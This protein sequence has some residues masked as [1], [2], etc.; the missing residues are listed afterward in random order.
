MLLNVGWSEMILLIAGLFIGL[1]IAALRARHWREQINVHEEKNQSLEMSNKKK[2]TQLKDLKTSVQKHKANIE[3]LSDK[4]SQSIENKHSLTHQVNE[5]DQAL[6]QLKEEAKNLVGQI[7]NMNTRATKAET[8]N[9]ELEKSLKLM[10]KGFKNLQTH[11]QEQESTII[12]MQN[13]ASQ[14]IERIQ[15]VTAQVEERDQTINQLQEAVN[16]RDI[17][18]Q[19][20]R[21]RSEEAQTRI[22]K[23]ETF[24][25]EQ[26][27]NIATSK[28][29]MQAMQD[30]LKIITGIGPKVSAI[31]RS[32]GINTFAKLAD[33]KENKIKEILETE[34]PRLLQ[35]VDP[36][37]WPEQAR[38]ASKGEWSALKALQESLKERRLPPTVDTPD[39]ETIQ[40]TA[41][42]PS[43]S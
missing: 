9:Q 22:I 34:N 21:T 20:W 6:D 29:Q 1:L 19:D 39:P 8:K 32:T 5:R 11:S 33:L 43:V 10:E 35:L 18:I 40:I 36:K 12:Q 7:K 37:P 26:E 25:K 13:Q 28:A 23:L 15:R 17:Q 38:L 27:Q 42:S 16:N 3:D 14:M 30:D 31:L 24:S 4:I 2:A 41:D